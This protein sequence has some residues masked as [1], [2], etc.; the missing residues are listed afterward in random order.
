MK[1]NK[2]SPKPLC[3]PPSRSGRGISPVRYKQ[4]VIVLNLI[5]CSCFAAQAQTP[6]VTGTR[7]GNLQNQVPSDKWQEQI[8]NPDGSINWGQYNFVA[9]NYNRSDII[10]YR[11]G[12]RYNYYYSGA[13]SFPTAPQTGSGG[14]FPGPYDYASTNPARTDWHQMSGQLLYAPDAGNDP[15]MARARTGTTICLSNG[16][17]VNDLRIGWTPDY[18]NYFN[19]NPDAATRQGPWLSASGGSLPTPAIAVA[20]AKYMASMSGISVFRNGIVG[21]TTTGNDPNTWK[22]DNN[23]YGT[24]RVQPDYPF[25]KLAN[26]KVPTAVAMT[27]NHEFALVTV[28]DTISRKGQLAVISIESTLPRADAFYS[29]SPY[30]WGV[31]NYG[32]VNRLKLLGYVDLPVA[33]PTSVQATADLGIAMGRIENGGDQASDRPDLSQQA[34]RDRWY[35]WSGNYY[36]RTSKAG[37]AIIASRAENKVVFVDLQP[38]YSYLRDM[39]F[40]TS[41]NY[42]TTTS[43]G[44]ADSQWPH[45]FNHAPQQRPVITAALTVPSPT[46]VAAGYRRDGAFFWDVS[47]YDGS[48]FGSTAYVASM[49]GT[50]RL[51]NVGMLNTHSSGAKPAPSLA[52]TVTIGKN[53]TFMAYGVQGGPSTNNLVITCRGDRAVYQVKPDGTVVQ[54]LKDS[55]L[56]DPVAAEVAFM[57]RGC[58]GVALVSVMDYSGKQAVNYVTRRYNGYSGTDTGFQF[59]FATPVPGMPFMFSVAEVL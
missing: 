27:L 14:W 7:T 4:L 55:R 11:L 51:F 43:T 54:V 50:L 8:L 33:A 17:T 24:W 12:P 49:D 16:Q 28:W 59:G 38:L 6:F 45:T 15:G 21:I 53:P 13:G 31:P 30:F 34:E 40:T 42:W 2:N 26:G 52:R 35:N 37:Y 20:R 32:R 46:A 19:E 5:L 36:Q 25:V 3:S 44:M 48:T 29:G 41:S 1:S 56:Q 47:D 22:V 18:G 10:D 23:D 39:M 58:G 57:W 9:A